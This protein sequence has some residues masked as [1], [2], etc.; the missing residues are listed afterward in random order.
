MAQLEQ[1]IQRVCL[2]TV[3]VDTQALAAVPLALAEEYAVIPIRIYGEQIV[4]A[5]AEESQP[6][7]AAE[8]P[9]VIRK[10]IRFVLAPERQIREAIASHYRCDVN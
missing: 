1:S 7:A 6:R 4:L 8:L 9:K 10:S 2:P 5:A 3:G